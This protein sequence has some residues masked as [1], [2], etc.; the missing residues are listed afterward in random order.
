VQPFVRRCVRSFLSR[1][2]LS[3]TNRVQF[4][5]RCSWSRCEKPSSVCGPSPGRQL[6][7]G[8]RLLL[9]RRQGING[10]NSRTHSIHHLFVG[11]HFG[12]V[13]A[14]IG[15]RLA[16]VTTQRRRPNRSEPNPSPRYSLN[17]SSRPSAASKSGGMRKVASAGMIDSK[18]RKSADSLAS[19]NFFSRSR[20]G[21]LAEW[22]AVARDARLAGCRVATPTMVCR[23]T[24][25]R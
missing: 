15:C 19:T 4:R 2:P 18:A 24:R 25:R 14:A 17:I 3:C 12:M 11:D 9:G 7:L 8:L 13:A 10:Q 23:Q 6:G 21:R 16:W 5:Y 22:C 1:L 20:S